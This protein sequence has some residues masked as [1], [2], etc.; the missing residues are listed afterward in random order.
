MVCRATEGR[1]ESVEVTDA[2]RACTMADDGYSRL[3]AFQCAHKP[4]Y[5][6]TDLSPVQSNTHL[7]TIG[8]N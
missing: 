2:F 6:Y 4:L 3:Y 8:Q 1:L 7:G 5:V